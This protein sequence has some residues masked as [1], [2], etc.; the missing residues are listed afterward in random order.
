LKAC[1]TP[2]KPLRWGRCCAQGYTVSVGD[3]GGYAPL[4]KNNEDACELIL[5]AVM[6][7]GYEPG[8]DIAI[9]IDAAATSFYQ[10]DRYR[11][12]RTSYRVMTSDEMTSLYEQWLHKY[13]I[14]SMEDGLAET[15]WDGFRQHTAALGSRVQIVGDDLL[16][17]N[18]KFIACAIEEKSCNTALIKLNQIGTVTETIAAVDLCRK[19]GW[20]Y[21]I[22]HWSGETEDTFMS[23]FAV[24][25]G[26]GQ[27]K[28]GSVCRGERIAKYNRLL[29]I[30]LELGERAAFGP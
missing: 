4:L 2:R 17:T 1:V 25:I 30:E 11:L 24:A 18:A 29:E 20:G 9:A 12:S 28:A 19:A 27:I 3:E 23:D 16:V 21:V 14:V 8:R 26:G 6:A 10:G 13:P 7:A 15:D 5:E 22:S